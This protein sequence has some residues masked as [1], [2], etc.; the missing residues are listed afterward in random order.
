MSSIAD[1]GQIHIKSD[2]AGFYCSSIESDFEHIK[3]KKF[4]QNECRGSVKSKRPLKMGLSIGLGVSVFLALVGCII[5]RCCRKRKLTEEKHDTPPEYELGLPPT[6]TADGLPSYI[7]SEGERGSEHGA[8]DVGGARTGDAS[9]VRGE[10]AS[11][12]SAGDAA[13]ARPGDGSSAH[14]EGASGRRAV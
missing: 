9:S 6:Y 1:L 5:W 10:G 12:H 13:S 7:A 14:Q 4:F 3:G 2:N 11:E 8:A